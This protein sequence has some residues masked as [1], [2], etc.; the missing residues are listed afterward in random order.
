MAT[1][2]R[3]RRLPGA[4]R[5]AAVIAAVREVFAMKGFHGTT[6]RELAQAA[7][8]SEALL[9]KH[10]PTKDDLYAAVLR[11]VID[12]ELRG[13]GFASLRDREPGTSTLVMLV[14]FLYRGLLSGHPRSGGRTDI[15]PRLMFQSML[16][17]GAFARLFHRE[18]PS[19]WV[20]MVEKSIRAATRAGDIP[21]DSAPAD[22]R[23][24]FAHHLAVMLL[25]HHL[26]DPPIVRYGVPRDRLVEHAVRFALR[27]IGLS[28]EAILRDYD[29]KRLA[30]FAR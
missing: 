23:A 16:G 7:G 30:A 9:F 21:R 12:D 17:D 14:H 25:I 22:L 26:A 3:A 20:S 28:D 13:P 5:R 15:L 24:W 8:V 4:E 2:K 29:P 18:V 27:G 1:M 11:S 6:T 19:R 10:F